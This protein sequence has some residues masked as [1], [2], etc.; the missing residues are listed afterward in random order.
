[1]HQLLENNATVSYTSNRVIVY[2]TWDGVRLY[3]LPWQQGTEDVSMHMCKCLTLA[4][5]L[6]NGDGDFISPSLAGSQ[7]AYLAGC[8]ISRYI[9][10]HIRLRHAGQHNTLTGFLTGPMDT[11]MRQS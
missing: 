4:R 7:L 6:D 8:A 9:L 11:V 2:V 10:R 1:M 3:V 5:L